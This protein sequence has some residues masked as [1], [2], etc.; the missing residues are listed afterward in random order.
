MKPKNT[1]C[2]W[3]DKEALEAARFY[4]ATFPD[5]KVIAVHNPPVTIVEAS[6]FRPNPLTN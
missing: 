1:I 4:D 2:P 5:T 3:F 6:V